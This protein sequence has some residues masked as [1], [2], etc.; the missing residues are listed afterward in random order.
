MIM[1]SGST[2]G[3]W[4]FGC[5]RARRETEKFNKRELIRNIALGKV[6]TVSP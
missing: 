1:I 5:M 4:I 2:G 6:A 3:I